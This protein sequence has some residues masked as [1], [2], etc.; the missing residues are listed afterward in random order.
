MKFEWDEEK[1]SVI[2]KNIRS[3]LRQQHLFLMIPITLKCMILN[4]VAKKTA[5]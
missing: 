1:I 2:K 5:T 3:H 4:T